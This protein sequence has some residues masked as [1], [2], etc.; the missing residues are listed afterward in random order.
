MSTQELSYYNE[1]DRLSVRNLYM[2]EDAVKVVS[3]KFEY[4]TIEFFHLLDV[5]R[6]KISRKLIDELYLAPK[7]IE[8]VE[9][10]GDAYA[11]DVV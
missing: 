4:G 8:V 2:D 10:N 1:I 11:I 7:T 9:F 5:H 3:G 6:D